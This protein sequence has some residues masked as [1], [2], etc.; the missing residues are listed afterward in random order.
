VLAV[1]L[2]DDQRLLGQGL[3][4]RGQHVRRDAFQFGLE[5]VEALRAVEQGRD[6]Q[7]G[8]AVADSRQRVGER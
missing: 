7:Q 5:L 4:A 1:R 8:P 2:G 3:Q 6:R